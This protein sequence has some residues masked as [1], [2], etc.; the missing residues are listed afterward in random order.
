MSPTYLTLAPFFFSQIKF[1][2]MVGQRVYHR[3]SFTP[4]HTDFLNAK[5]PESAW[6]HFTMLYWLEQVKASVTAV[7]EGARHWREYEGGMVHI[8]DRLWKDHTDPCRSV[9]SSR[10]DIFDAPLRVPCTFPSLN[11][12]QPNKSRVH[13]SWKITHIP[14]RRETSWEIREYKIPAAADR[15]QEKARFRVL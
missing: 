15:A 4:L 12:Q 10:D 2:A 13:S 11:K 6:P 3:Y 7:L 8:K 9:R 14:H 1:V 5:H